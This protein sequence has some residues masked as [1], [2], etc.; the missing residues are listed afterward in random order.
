MAP[1]EFGMTSLFSGQ[2][3]ASTHSSKA[4]EILGQ[5]SGVRPSANTGRS[6]TVGTADRNSLSDT[7]RTPEIHPDSALHDRN[8]AVR[9]LTRATTTK[10][11]STINKYDSNVT[12]PLLISRLASASGTLV[13]PRLTIIPGIRTNTSYEPNASALTSADL[14]PISAPVTYTP[15]PASRSTLPGTTPF[16]TNTTPRLKANFCALTPAADRVPASAPATPAPP[17]RLPRTPTNTTPNPEPNVG[18]LAS[19]DLASSSAPATCT[20]APAS[21]G[22]RPGTPIIRNTTPRLEANFSALTPAANRVPI[23]APATPAPPSRLPGPPTNT[24]P[25]LERNVSELFSTADLVPTSVPCNSPVSHA[26]PKCFRIANV[27]L[28][29]TNIDLLEALRTIDPDLKDQNPEISL[30][31][32][33]IGSTKTALLNLDRC[34]GY[35]GNLNSNEPKHQRVSN[36]WLV[37]DSQFYDL[38]PM[39]TPREEIVAEFVPPIP[40]NGYT[41][42][43]VLTSTRFQCHRSDGTRRPRV[44][45]L[46]KP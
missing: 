11:N 46:E 33:C 38:T 16:A 36:A 30:F 8:G 18:V 7:T 41:C 44:R 29:W 12:R 27:P 28:N 6:V 34:S 19:S 26:T 35:F 20:P 37:I 3:R 21:R 32:A 31:P 5:I 17:S 22:A 2:P 45:I 14:G 23:S 4:A 1:W 10:E 25:S 13:A 15:A 40:L 39:N 9:I 43:D 42:S 24:A